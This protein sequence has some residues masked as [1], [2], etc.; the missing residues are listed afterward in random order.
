MTEYV[1]GFCFS[2]DR[3]KVLLINKTKPDWQKGLLNGVGGKIEYFDQNSYI[4]MAREFAEETGIATS[5]DDWYG[6]CILRG[7]SFKVECY[8]MFCQGDI[9]TP[10]SLTEEVVG[11]YEVS[12]ILNDRVKCISNLKWLITLALDPEYV[13]VDVWY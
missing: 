10:R 5:Y 2:Q 8:R 13:G 4:A 12:D 9:P 1:L 11:I 7:K 3:T 6:Y